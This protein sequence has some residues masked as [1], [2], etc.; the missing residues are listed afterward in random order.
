MQVITDAIDHSF[1]NAS[2]MM[3]AYLYKFSDVRE[4]QYFFRVDT[5]I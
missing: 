1:A 2:K 3:K 4:C 5:C